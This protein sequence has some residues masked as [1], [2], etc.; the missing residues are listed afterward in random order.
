[1]KVDFILIDIFIIAIHSLND[2]CKPKHD[3]MLFLACL[4]CLKAL[5]KPIIH[6]KYKYVA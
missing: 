2:N 4:N 6:F 1:M 3:L 5:K